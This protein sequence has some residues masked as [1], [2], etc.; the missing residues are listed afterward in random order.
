MTNNQQPVPVTSSFFLTRV[1]NLMRINND[2]ITFFDEC[3]KKNGNLFKA[4]FPGFEFN[5]LLEP[6]GIQHVLEKNHMNFK[7]SMVYDP[8]KLALGNGLLTSDGAF[9]KSQRKMIQPLFNTSFIK[10]ICHDISV[11]TDEFFLNL[12]D[13]PFDLNKELANL[14]IG[15]ACRA[16]FATS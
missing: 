4:K 11:A 6:E 5:Y 12:G 2:P 1:S 16:F 14:T 3:I 10:E 7:K 13:G 15:I 9:W 8:L